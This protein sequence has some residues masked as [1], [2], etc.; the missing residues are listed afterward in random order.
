MEPNRKDQTRKTD[1]AVR[2]FTEA[3]TSSPWKFTNDPWERSYTRWQSSMLLSKAPWIII[4]AFPFQI[5]VYGL[6][7]FSRAEGIKLAIPC[8]GIGMLLW[9]MWSAGKFKSP[10]RKTTQ[11]FQVAMWLILFGASHGIVFSEAEDVGQLERTLRWIIV[12]ALGMGTFEEQLIWCG[13]ILGARFL[14]KYVTNTGNSVVTW[15]LF[16]CHLMLMRGVYAFRRRE[17]RRILATTTFTGILSSDYSAERSPTGAPVDQAWHDDYFTAEEWKQIAPVVEREGEDMV[18]RGSNSNPVESYDWIHTYKRLGEGAYGVVRV[19]KSRTTGEIRAMKIARAS[20]HSASEASKRNK[21]MTSEALLLRML[22]HPNVVGFIEEVT[23]EQE[24]HLVMELCDGGSL[25]QLISTFGALDQ[26][27]VRWFTRNMVWG[28]QYLHRHGISHQDLKPGNCLLSRQGAG[29]ALKLA[30]LGLGTWKAG[31]RESSKVVGTPEY[32]APETGAKSASRRRMDI[33]ALG[34]CVL[35]MMT[36]RTLIDLAGEHAQLC[37]QPAAVIKHLQSIKVDPR[38]PKDVPQGAPHE[39]IAA[40]LRVQPA[41]RPTTLALDTHPFLDVLECPAASASIGAVLKRPVMDIQADDLDETMLLPRLRRHAL[42]WLNPRAVWRWLA[43]LEEPFLNPDRERRFQ[44]WMA[45]DPKFEYAAAVVSPIYTGS[46]IYQFQLFQPTNADSLQ[47]RPHSAV[48]LAGQAMLLLFLF[49]ICIVFWIPR[50][51]R[52][53][54]WDNVVFVCRWAKVA[55]ALAP[56]P[57]LSMSVTPVFYVA[58]FCSAWITPNL[59]ELIVWTGLV[60]VKILCELAYHLLE[61]WYKSVAVCADEDAS[62]C[63]ASSIYSSPVPADALDRTASGV[64]VVVFCAS[65]CAYAS[66][67]VRLER[68]HH[69]RRLTKLK[70]VKAN[71]QERTSGNG[72]SSTAAGSGSRSQSPKRDLRSPPFEFSSELAGGFPS[73]PRISPRRN[74]LPSKTSLSPPRSGDSGSPRREGSSG[75]SNNAAQG[76]SRTALRRRPTSGNDDGVRPSTAEVD[77]RI[78]EAVLSNIEAGEGTSNKVLRRR[79]QRG[80]MELACSD[81]ILGAGAAAAGRGSEDAP[82]R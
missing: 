73:P 10:D 46:V 79:D 62:L 18:K 5:A 42:F 44:L 69:F 13:C 50:A 29:V 54:Q 82:A 78:D 71:G 3:F 80:Y 6:P 61:D 33:W 16:S 51:K 43:E 60:T 20:K 21:K 23:L 65:L 74:R 57:A 52:M 31:S 37:N 9:A 64:I 25:A 7:K 49:W 55:R 45:Q 67:F 24:A 76:A 77:P 2:S 28:L 53:N 58:L 40:C 17:W 35:E 38:L 26:P 72:S 47:S 19:V 81:A 59:G 15:V 12:A 11:I 14:Y 27:A 56:W 70:L 34:V 63:I 32:I 48:Q 4:A 1:G 22:Q 68:R 75:S 41:L 66:F 39:F 30:D 36:A 8:L